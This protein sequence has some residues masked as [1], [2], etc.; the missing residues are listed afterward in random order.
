MATLNPERIN[1]QKKKRIRVWTVVFLLEALIAVW[2]TGELDL[3]LKNIKN[4]SWNGLPVITYHAALTNI[5]TQPQLRKIYLLLELM[6]A[7]WVMYEDA[8]MRQHIS[9][10]D[11]VML[12]PDIEVP[13][14]AGNG[15]HGTERFLTEA[16]LEEKLDVFVYDGRSR[17]KLPGNGGIV[18]QM[19][20][21]GRKEIIVYDSGERHCI[22]LGASGAGKTRRELLVLIWLQIIAGQSVI[23]S[24]VK[25]EL[26]YYTK[27]YAAQHQYKTI[28]LDIRNPKKSAHYNFL[29]PIR[30]AFERGDSADGIDKTW[31][32]VSVLVG[33][34]K[35][36]PIW[37]NGE[38]A[39]IA[40]VILIVA[41]EAPRQYRNLANVYYFMAYMC[42]S[43]EMGNMPLN[44]FLDS[45]PDNHPA[46]GVFAMATIAADKTRSS[47]FTSALGTLRLFTNPNVAEMTSSTDFRLE[48][49]SSSKTIL[50][51]MI[52][53]DNKKLYPLVSI[54]ITQ[55]YQAQVKQASD[56]GLRL[57]IDTDYDLDEAGNFPFIPVLGNMVSAGRS[58]GVRVNLVLQDYQ[59]LESKYK[60]DFENIKTNCQLKIYLKSDNEKTLKSISD[61]LG[62]YT[63][64]SVNASTSVS[65]NKSQGANYSSSSSLTARKLMEPAEIGRIKAPYALVMQTGEY[66]AITQLPDLSEYRLNKL[67][68][69]GDKKHNA[70][71]IMQREASRKER[72]IP[73][74]KLWGVWNDYTVES[75]GS[76]P[77]ERVSFL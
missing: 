46:K 71:I 57:P 64:E 61:S 5:M 49:I 74:I 34:Q 45:L 69:L 29:Q 70:K 66:P 35:G 44:M 43:D 9:S 50:Y 55:L 24:D 28:D 72:D 12:T 27:P 13:V 51:M 62:N 10:V 2:L 75:A 23:V 36:E 20:K 8:D 6:F 32:L 76:D 7:A 39:A 15:Q 33:E 63:V 53:D 77:G 17:P 26:Y 11:T 41:I 65:D 37:Y 1:S 60:D 48:D 18:L 73:P 47:F 42:Q 4:D 19:K 3:I 58:R 54:L 25:G 16:E 38:C 14:K 68:G 22:I 40:A 30:D 52:P 67:Y 21:S 59:Q 31:D 56:H